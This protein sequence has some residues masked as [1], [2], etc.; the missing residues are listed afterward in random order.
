MMVLMQTLLPDPVAPAMRTWG[1]VVRSTTTGLPRTSRPRAMGRP[2]FL[3]A[4]P[5]FV[6]FDDAAD[7]D[8]RRGCGWGL[9]CR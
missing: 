5:E 3:R 2:P 4:A 6:G 8:G 7:G 9:R 1:M